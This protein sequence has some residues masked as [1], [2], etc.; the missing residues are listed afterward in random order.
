MASWVGLIAIGAILW[1]L[2]PK[3]AGLYEQI[4]ISLPVA[5]QWLFA[6][7]GFVCAYPLVWMTASCVLAWI[8]GRYVKSGGVIELLLVS[9]FGLCLAFLVVALF[10]PLIG[11]REGIHRG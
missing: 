8:L 6:I 10:I 9:C 3:F 4:N 1:A 11:L 5:T 2:V 7:P